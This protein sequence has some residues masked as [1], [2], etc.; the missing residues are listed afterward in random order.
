MPYRRYGNSSRRSRPTPCASRRG[1]RPAFRGKEGHG[2]QP[3]HGDSLFPE[4]MRPR[5]RDPY[6][7]D[8]FVG[9]LPG[10]TVRHQQRLLPGV[11]ADWRWP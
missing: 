7:W 6:P 8:A 1:K 10:D 2:D 4:H 5:P 11:P 9:P 3:G